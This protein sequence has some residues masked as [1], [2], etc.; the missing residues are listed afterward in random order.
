MDKKKVIFSWSGGKDSAYCL[1]YVLSNQLYDVCYLLTTLNGNLHRISMHGV[2]EEL[3]EQQAAQIGIPLLKAYVYEGTNAE[4]EKQM[5]SILTKAKSEGIQGVVFGDLFLA[6]LRAYRESQLA[7]I[8]MSAFFPL[9]GMDTALLV[10]DFIRLQ[11]KSILSSTNDAY[12]GKEWVGRLIDESFIDQLPARVDPCGENG[13]FHSFCFDG[14]IFQH[15]IMFSIGEKVY[16]PLV[17][18]QK[19]KDHSTSTE[20]TKGFWYCDFIPVE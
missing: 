10:R 3:V 15:K 11:F 20:T 13:E 16:K 12:L 18:K 9:W 5:E 1:H 17:L 19:D 14:P 2:R 8:G 7:N 6:D 4:Y